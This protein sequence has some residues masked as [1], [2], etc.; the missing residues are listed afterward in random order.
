MKKT[1]NISLAQFQALQ[2]ANQFAAAAAVN[3]MFRLVGS[4][5]FGYNIA[6]L[7][8]LAYSGSASSVDELARIQANE[9]V[10]LNE[11]TK[12]KEE[13]NSFDEIVDS[14]RGEY[15]QAAGIDNA[16]TTALSKEE[17]FTLKLQELR[18]SI[19]KAIYDIA[20]NVV[21]DKKAEQTA[22]EQ[23]EKIQALNQRELDA[24]LKIKEERNLEDAKKLS[25]DDLD[26]RIKQ[27]QQALNK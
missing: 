1:F 6:K 19:A 14:L 16:T 25:N 24:L 8:E 7:F 12:K 27:L 2:T 9:T 18:V 5:C 3:L 15:N 13:S 23:V 21:K 17:L 4:D 26:N 10:R 20:I 11:I 22:E